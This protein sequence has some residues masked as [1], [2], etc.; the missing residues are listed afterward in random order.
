[1]ILNFQNGRQ[2][3]HSAK[4]KVLQI[5]KKFLLAKY[6]LQQTV[7]QLFVRHDAQVQLHQERWTQ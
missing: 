1:M 3:F 2:L 7:K 6:C 4:L 5:C